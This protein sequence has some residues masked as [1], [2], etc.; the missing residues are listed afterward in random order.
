M[1]DG[2][3][4]RS[5]KSQ[6]VAAR[7]FDDA[8]RYLAASLVSTRLSAPVTYIPVGQGRVKGA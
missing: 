5:T 6:F 4:R 3:G 7:L 1:R 8:S 2:R